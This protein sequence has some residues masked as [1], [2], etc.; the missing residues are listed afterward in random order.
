MMNRKREALIIAS[1]LEVLDVVGNAEVRMIIET[2]K[3]AMDKEDYTWACKYIQDLRG[4]LK[5]PVSTVWQSAHKVTADAPVPKAPLHPRMQELALLV[6]CQTNVPSYVIAAAALKRII[7]LEDEKKAYAEMSG[8]LP[9]KMHNREHPRNKYDREILHKVHVDVYDVLN[10]F[11]VW[12]PEVAHAVKKLLAPG[13]RGDK[14]LL[15]DLQ[16]AQASIE[17]A[18]RREE[19]NNVDPKR[20]E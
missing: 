15:Q 3:E 14:S 1:V 18:V 20:A 10:A 9:N 11:E 2:L 16:E 7:T 6:G 5:L 13:K 8:A 17:A 19:V 12:K 4:V